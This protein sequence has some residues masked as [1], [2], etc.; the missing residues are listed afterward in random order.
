ACE[1]AAAKPRAAGVVCR[2]SAIRP[3]PLLAYTPHTWILRRKRGNG[4]GQEPARRWDA[5]QSACGAGVD[6]AQAYDASPGAWS[7]T[8]KEGRLGNRGVGGSITFPLETRWSPQP[9]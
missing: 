4:K 1:D 9:S 5:W 3:H 8:M 7:L 2:S 6:Q